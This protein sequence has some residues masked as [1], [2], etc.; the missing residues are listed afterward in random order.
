[1]RKTFIIGGIA[2]A[3][4]TAPVLS[5]DI[6]NTYVSLAVQ[7]ADGI[8][9]NAKLANMADSTIKGRAVGAGTGVPTDITAAQAAAIIG[10]VGGAVKTKMLFNTRDLTT[11]SGSQVITGMGFQPTWCSGAGTVPGQADYTVF[12]AFADS[13]RASY[14]MFSFQGATGHSND[15]ASFMLV[16]DVTNANSQTATIASYDAD[17]LTL[18]WTKT[19][20]PS[21]TYNFGILCGR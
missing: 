1:M 13:A 5:Q 8:L 10:S 12:A 18:S 16:V 7:V 2:V 3:L 4:F 20:T 14:N 9:T 15:N 11:A 21:G 17:G 6:R 19:G